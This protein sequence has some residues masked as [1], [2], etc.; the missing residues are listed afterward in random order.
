MV[1]M[2]LQR[3]VKV[4][5]G[6]PREANCLCGKF[7]G[8]RLRRRGALA[9]GG[10]SHR[11][12]GWAFQ[13]KRPDARSAGC[14]LLRWADAW[15]RDCSLKEIANHA[16]TRHPGIGIYQEDMQGLPFIHL[17]S[18]DSPKALQCRFSH[19]HF[20]DE[21]TEAEVGIAVVAGGRA[22]IQI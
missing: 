20:T 21:K 9:A 2:T 17:C 13:W 4:M 3:P 15:R 8:G 16:C 6:D 1:L 7:I 22:G 18:L 19:P 11:S 14:C 5:D 10:W 12:T